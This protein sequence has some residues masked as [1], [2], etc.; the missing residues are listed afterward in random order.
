MGQLDSLIKEFNRK[1][2]DNIAFLGVPHIKVP[3]IPWQKNI[4]K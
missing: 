4:S 1:N 2:K 3:K